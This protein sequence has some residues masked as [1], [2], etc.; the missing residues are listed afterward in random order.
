MSF[1]DSVAR[2]IILEGLD[3]ALKTM[4][5]M[6]ANEGQES[7]FIDPIKPSFIENSLL[8]VDECWRFVTDEAHVDFMGEIMEAGNQIMDEAWQYAQVIAAEIDLFS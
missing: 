4:E 8:P 1:G 6:T 5:S 2:Q 3:D 7:V